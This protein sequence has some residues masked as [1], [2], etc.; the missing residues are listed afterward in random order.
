MPLLYRQQYVDLLVDYHLNKSIKQQYEKF[1]E[2][3]YSVCN[4]QFLM[5]CEKP[6]FCFVI[7]SFSCIHLNE[8][9]SVLISLLLLFVVVCFTLF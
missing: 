1:E 2:G 4:R 8:V 3:F 5:V 9:N 7:S 6:N